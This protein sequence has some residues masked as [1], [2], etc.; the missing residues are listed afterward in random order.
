MCSGADQDLVL[1]GGGNTSVK[2]PFTDIIGNEIPALYVK[3]SGW[4]LATIE[5]E[6]FSP[7]RMDYM[8]NVPK[9][10][11]LTD[12]ELVQVQ[13]QALLSPTAPAPSIESMVHA[14]IPFTFVDHTHAD[15]V[16]LL[17]N[18]SKGRAYCEEV[19]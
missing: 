13:K 9:L 15:A 6:G 5:K 1:H 14:M 18:T 7:V 3:G 10:P 19:H 11:S 8:L 16:C 17:T 12:T 4:D 2:M